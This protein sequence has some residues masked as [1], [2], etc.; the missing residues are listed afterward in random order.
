MEGPVIQGTWKTELEEGSTT[1]TEIFNLTS[2]W[3]VSLGQGVY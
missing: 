1:I 3:L 2:N